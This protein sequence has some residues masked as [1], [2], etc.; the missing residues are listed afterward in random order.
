MP[1]DISCL[2]SDEFPW[3]IASNN[4]DWGSLYNRW[5]SFCR[6]SERTKIYQIIISVTLY[7]VYT[8]ITC[9]GG[10]LAK[11]TTIELA[12]IG[13]LLKFKID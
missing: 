11:L 12:P 7:H 13:T 4:R 5:M 6:R 2:T 1:L 3:K 8:S 10:D 9:D